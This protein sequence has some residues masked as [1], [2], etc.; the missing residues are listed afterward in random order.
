V[1]ATQ[2]LLDTNVLS[3]LMRP[4]PNPRV[5]R[6]VAELEQPLVSAVVFHELVYGKD[7]LPDGARK[8][9]MAGEIEGFRRQFEENTVSIDAETAELSGKLRAQAQRSG[10]R[11]E[12]I[13]ALIAA[14][15]V[16]AR[17]TLATRNQKDFERLG[18]ELVNPWTD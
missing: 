13:D 5:V 2:F 17:V 3:E 1:K 10:F 11:L 7:L 15:A 12:P 16:R 8:E 18:I 9:K 14:S 6:F 4:A